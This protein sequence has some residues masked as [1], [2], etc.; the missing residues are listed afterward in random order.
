[1]VTARPD[2]PDEE[3][4]A[5]PARPDEITAKRH[6]PPANDG[7]VAKPVEKVLLT[8]KAKWPLVGSGGLLV[9]LFMLGVGFTRLVGGETEQTGPPA[10]TTAANER[11]TEAATAAN[12]AVT[13]TTK[14][15][16]APSDTLLTAIL[17]SGAALLIT[18]FLYS[19][20][21]TIKIAGVAEIGL[22]TAELNTI[23]K[24]VKAKLGESSPRVDEAKQAVV[25]ELHRE[26]E[27][28]GIIQLNDDEVK[29]VAARIVE[30]LT[31]Q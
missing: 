19:R 8:D 17:A 30:E 9:L 3:A 5:Q 1:M 22:T 4:S 7:S 15:K 10:A 28:A 23:D 18:G 13:T 24:Q 2:R 20:I 31:G 12:Q 26:K 6:T 21:T 14:T 27:R 16:N 11:T 25:K 29:R